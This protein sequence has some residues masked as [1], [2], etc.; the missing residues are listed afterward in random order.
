MYLTSEAYKAAVVQHART[1]ALDF[2]LTLDSGEVINLDETKVSLGTT[3]FKEASTCNSNLQV[4][5]VFA[6]SLNFTMLKQQGFDSKDFSRA[7]VVAKVGLLVGSSYVWVPLG[8]FNVVTVG[9]RTSSV[10]LECLDDMYKLNRPL[11]SVAVSFPCS[12]YALMQ[13][14]CSGCGVSMTPGTSVELQNLQFNLQAFELKDYTCRDI[15]SFV[16]MLLKRNFRFNRAGY[17]ESFWYTDNAQKTNASTRIAGATFE[18]YHVAVTGVSLEDAQGNVH[19]AGTDD[20]LVELKSNPLVQ[21]SAR[22]ETLVSELLGVLSGLSYVPYKAKYVGDPSWQAGDLLTH[23]M[24]DGSTIVSPIMEH[25]LTF[26]G[27][28]QLGAVGKA[29]EQVRQLTSAAK[30][31][32]ELKIKLPQDLNQ[33]LSSMEQTILN[34]SALITN[35]LGFYPKVD[36][37]P[38]GSIAAYYLMSTPEDTAE[39]TVWAFTSGGIGVSH[40]GLSGPYTSSWTADDSIVAQVITASMIKAGILQSRDGGA[41]FYLDLDNGILRMDASEISI[42]SRSVAETL[43]EMQSNTGSLS[44]RVDELADDTND[45]L[46]S[47]ETSLALKVDSSAVEVQIT[48]ALKDGATKVDTT[49]GIRMDSSGVTVDK[50]G[51]STSTNINENGML[52]S[53]KTGS[54]L[55]AV[56]TANDQGVDAINLTARQYLIIGTRSRFENYGDDRT[57]CF[58]I[59]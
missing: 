6:N 59:G 16:G 50:T 8:K 37:N 26:R 43:N 47:L 13:N 7:I 36:R 51:A 11:S 2:K 34:Q 1:W 57:G 19:V 49:T 5:S 22:A 35:A 44:S 14:I 20:Y 45:R 33:G 39:T 55:E 3:R 23:I 40:T 15:V 18:D 10:V 31:L 48:E 12:V 17:L 25:T 42:G 58:W 56:L 38:D 41:T 29:P 53:R 24:S 4:G 32:Q 9:K 54:T 52:V 46:S 21:D 30:I 27:T 28:S